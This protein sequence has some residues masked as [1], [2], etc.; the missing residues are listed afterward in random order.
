MD[1]SVAF[2]ILMIHI[3]AT[4]EKRAHNRLLLMQTA[5]IS[6]VMPCCV[7][8][9]KSMFGCD[10]RISATASRSSSIASSRAVRSF[11]LLRRCQRRPAAMR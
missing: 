3:G 8:A 1:R 6:A 5:T 7:S 9:F 10:S 2:F 11:L 4:L